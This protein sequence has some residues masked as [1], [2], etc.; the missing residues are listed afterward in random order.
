MKKR[1]G[2]ATA[3]ALLAV[4]AVLFAG[5][6]KKEEKK[7]SLKIGISIYRED[8]TFISNMMSSL[9]RYAK[10]LEREKKIKISVDI[11]N[12]N[13]NQNTQN[14]QVERYISLG[15]DVLCINM[16]DR[17]EASTIIDKAMAADIP[18]IFFNR[19]PVEEDM[20][21]WEK[22]YYIG[23]DAKE[24]AVLEGQIILEAMA[25][26]RTAIDRNGDGVLQYAMLE[27]EIRHQDS[28]VRTEWSVQSVKDGGVPLEKVTG[29]IANWER[30][31]A[32]ALVEQ[33]L[34]EYGNQIEVMIC[35]NDDMALGAVDALARA[36]STFCNIVG[37]DGTPVAI[38][39]VDAGK[40]LGTV[41]S[42]L[43]LHAQAIL[44]FAYA[45]GMDEAV[46]PEKW[47]LQEGKYI[48]IPQQIYTGTQSLE[49]TSP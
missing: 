19:E 5:Q 23:S 35:N 28:M 6:N 15:Y 45:M 24:Q 36:G 34:V 33:W 48:R 47:Q 17:A 16:V 3:V 38:E 18:V 9:E 13:E 7:T 10:D 20:E 32:S 29:G 11:S 2:L 43:D 4:A 1:I 21:R 46:D 22:L 31:Q 39:A 40:M 26:D 37:I 8:D 49:Q 30:S 25:R 41:V 42:N 44:D 27:G 14:D 12:A